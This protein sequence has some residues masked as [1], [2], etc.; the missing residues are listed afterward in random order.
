MMA[1]TSSPLGLPVIPATP[2]RVSLLCDDSDL[3]ELADERI[4]G[5]S[6][7]VTQPTQVLSNP[8]T[9]LKRRSSPPP[10][11]DPPIS[12]SPPRPESRPP[13]FSKPVSNQTFPRRNQQYI[14]N[15]FSRPLPLSPKMSAAAIATSRPSSHALQTKPTIPQKRTSDIIALSDDD[16][17]DDD[18][19][20]GDRADIK[21]TTFSR[22]VRLRSVYCC[23]FEA[24]TTS[25]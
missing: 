1:R 22:M 18:E 25:L 9:T 20:M 8:A 17:D 21:P 10:F 24:I 14:S 4:P 2:P 3:D 5:T 19:F 23:F 13:T 11:S 15:F 16:D 7:F 12:S 6:P